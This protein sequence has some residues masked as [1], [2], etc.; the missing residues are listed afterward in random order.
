M[1]FVF[2]FGFELKLFVLDLRNLFSVDF[3]ELDSFLWDMLME[4]MKFGSVFIDDNDDIVF[5]VLVCSFM[6]I[7]EIVDESELINV[8]IGNWKMVRVFLF[9]V[10]LMLWIFERMNEV[11]DEEDSWK[12]VIKKFKKIIFDFFIFNVLSFSGNGIGEEYDELKFF[13]LLERRRKFSIIKRILLLFLYG[14]FIG[15]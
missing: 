5:E 12:I 3:F 1:V 8:L 15:N 4:N 10:G 14:I 6:V 2:G 13:L 9:N 11:V 7:L